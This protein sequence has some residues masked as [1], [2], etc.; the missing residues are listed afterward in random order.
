MEFEDRRTDR[1]CLARRKNGVSAIALSLDGKKVV[2]GYTDG[3]VKL[4][5][6]DTG[7]I[8]TK[9]T[10][11]TDY[12]TSV[13]WNRDCGRVVSASGD[14]DSKGVGCGEQKDRPS[15]RDWA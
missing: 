11:H 12:V 5:D 7:K 9:W 13:C 6:I 8:I 3:S 1:G 15:N 2:C 4:W 10:G 14:G